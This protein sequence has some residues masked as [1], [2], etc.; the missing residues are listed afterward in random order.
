MFEFH[1]ELLSDE[2]RTLAFRDA[3][4]KTVGPDDVVVDIGAGSGILSLFACEAGAR[5]VYA[6]E[7]LHTADAV[8]I[9]AK[10]FGD[11]D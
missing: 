1:R 8:A 2:V 5:H 3:I 7:Q 4:L 10:G 11:G 6:I 9:M